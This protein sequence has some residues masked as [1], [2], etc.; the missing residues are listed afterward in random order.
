MSYLDNF[1]FQIT[2]KDESPKLVFLHGLMGFSSNWRTIAKAFEDQYQILVYDQRG[3]GRSFHPQSG[4][5][6]EDYANDLKLILDELGWEKV[7]LVGH[8]MGGRNS[9]SFT[10]NN[11]QRVSRLVVEDIGPDGD[12]ANIDRI[13]SLVNFVPV[14]FSDRKSARSFFENEFIERFSH[15]HNVKALASYLHANLMQN[16]QKQMV[17][18]FSK[19][20][21][22]ESV[23]A[24]RATDRWQEWASLKLPI[25]LMRGGTSQEL[26]QEV[27][28]KMLEEN[29]NA[30]GHLFTG[31]GHWIHSEQPDEFIKV[32]GEFLS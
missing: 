18:R 26:S 15:N 28:E 13:R 32:L 10:A 23:E 20:A 31:V 4:F 29:E 2:G 9:M 27:Y 22:L 14:P 24:G 6:P 25:L 19:K 12:R 7:T 16:E 3:H 21:I 17:W 8:S 1:H 30:R 5:R 11:M